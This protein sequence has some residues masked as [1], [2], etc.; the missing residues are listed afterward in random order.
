MK[1]SWARI[2][3]GAALCFIL[4]G[5]GT[6]FYFW[7]K[8]IFWGERFEAGEQLPVATLKLLAQR[9][10]WNQAEMLLIFVDCDC[11][12]CS[13][14]MNDL[15]RPPKRTGPPSNGPSGILVG[16]EECELLTSLRP[17]FQIVLDPQGDLF[18]A[19]EVW[20]VPSAFRLDRKGRVLEAEIGWG[21]E[22]FVVRYFNKGR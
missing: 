18:R 17:R 15:G 6:V 8:A 4:L 5:L 16:R 3:S 13:A 14:M 22:A 11:P 1:A 10:D 19:F 12:S 9:A 2:W 20:Q 7:G 21:A